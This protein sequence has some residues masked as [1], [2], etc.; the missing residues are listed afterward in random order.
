[1]CPEKM[2]TSETKKTFTVKDMS[3]PLSQQLRGKTS[4]CNFSVIECDERAMLCRSCRVDN[5]FC[6]TEEL[7]DLSSL[8][9]TTSGEDVSEAVSA[10]IDD[11]W[12]PKNEL[13]GITKHGAPQMLCNRDGMVGEAVKLHWMSTTHPL[14]ITALPPYILLCMTHNQKYIIQSKSWI[15]F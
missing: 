8:K 15:I 5:N 12:M 11:N 3:A 9:G 4:A 14:L 6:S 10:V 13:C 7:L 1:M 2:S